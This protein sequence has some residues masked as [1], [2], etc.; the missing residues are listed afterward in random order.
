MKKYVRSVCMCLKR[1][2]VSRRFAAAVLMTA[3]LIALDLFPVFQSGIHTADGKTT[4]SYDLVELIG[5][6]GFT[7]FLGFSLITAVLPY[8]GAFCEDAQN[9]FL[10][11]FVKRG[12]PGVYAAGTVAACGI[13]SFLCVFLAQALCLGIYGLFLPVV[14]EN[15]VPGNYTY[16]L[17]QEEHYVLYLLVQTSLYALRGAF[18]GLMSLLASTFVRNK[19]V[20]YSV[21]FILYYFLMKFGYSVFDLP[22]TLNVRGIYFSFVF[23]EAYELRSLAYTLLI[24]VLVGVCAGAAVARGFR[25]CV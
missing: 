8:S 6:S 23:G 19:F 18:F 13:S 25:R 20:I 5:F 3:L 16:S 4:Y 17:I 24:T 22:M 1:A 10:I 9:R 15:F 7:M 14:G 11:P 12:S 21:P 2:L